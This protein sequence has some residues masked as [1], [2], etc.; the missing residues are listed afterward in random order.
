MQI[1]F[2]TL[3]KKVRLFW[4]LAVRMIPGVVLSPMPT[5]VSTPKVTK[6]T[7]ML[8]ANELRAMPLAQIREPMNVTYLQEE[9]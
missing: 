1:M 7:S 4:H 5:P 9:N 6:S 3:K 8:G 2:K